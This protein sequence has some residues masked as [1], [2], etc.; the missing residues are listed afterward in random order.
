M[1]RGLRGRVT[2]RRPEAISSIVRGVECGRLREHDELKESHAA[3][4]WRSRV[5]YCNILGMNTRKQDDSSAVYKAWYDNEL[6]SIV[7]L[8][9]DPPCSQPVRRAPLSMPGIVL[10]FPVRDMHG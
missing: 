3:R 8:I 4:F 1:E 7:R 2:Q 9:R 10:A 5:T 6:V